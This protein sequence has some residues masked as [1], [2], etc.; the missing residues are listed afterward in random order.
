MTNNTTRTIVSSVLVVGSGGAGLRAAIA[1][2]E[3]GTDVVV[4]GKSHSRDAHTVLAAG[5]ID[6][7]LGT[8]DP[9]DSWERHFADEEITRLVLDHHLEP[10]A[11]AR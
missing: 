8:V 11:A 2:H 10:V 9:E 4:I 7:A 3:A 5:G 1:A 6:A